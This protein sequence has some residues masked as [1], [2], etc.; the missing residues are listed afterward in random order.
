LGG[1]CHIDTLEACQKYGTIDECCTVNEEA[2][3]LIVILGPLVR[4]GPSHLLTDDSEVLR[5]MS[6]ARSPYRRSVWYDGIRLE[7]DYFNVVSER[8]ENRH[9]DLRTKMGL[10]VSPL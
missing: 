3:A 4:I 6:A 10:G 1:R 8:Y 9:N 2:Q 7:H 5:K